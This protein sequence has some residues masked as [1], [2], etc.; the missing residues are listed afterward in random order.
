[1]CFMSQTQLCLAFICESFPV[2]L[3]IISCA[4]VNH[5]LCVCGWLHVFVKCC[6]CICRSLHA[7]VDFETI[8]E[9][10][11]AYKSTYKWTPPTVYLSQISQNQITAKLRWPIVPCFH[12][13]QSRLAL[14]SGRE[15]YHF[16]HLKGTVF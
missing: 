12:Y 8:L 3:L 14:H 4:S 11:R 2:Y 16:A 7:S 5:F 9:S 10:R 6:L 1:M 15:Q 13:N